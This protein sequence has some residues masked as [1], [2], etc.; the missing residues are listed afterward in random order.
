MIKGCR[1]EGMVQND[2]FKRDVGGYT[3]KG[4]YV[5]ECYVE[6]C[7]IEGCYLM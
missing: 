3:V 5:E 1:T 7:C 2:A 6:A 4:C